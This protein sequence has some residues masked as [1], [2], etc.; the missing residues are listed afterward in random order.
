MKKLYINESEKDIIKNRYKSLGIISEQINI[1]FEDGSTETITSDDQAAPTPAPQKKT[2][3][4]DGKWK[5]CPAVPLDICCIDRQPEDQSPLKKVQKC[6]GTNPDGKYGPKT[7][8]ALEDKGYATN[9]TQEVYDKIMADCGKETP[10]EEPKQEE[11]PDVNPYADW[12]SQEELT[13]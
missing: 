10:K 1:T 4:C 8:K 3:F 2:Y 5:K 12:V 6:V 11:K 7:K 9:V 13:Q